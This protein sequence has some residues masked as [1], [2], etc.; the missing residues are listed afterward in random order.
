MVPQ[1]HWYMIDPIWTTLWGPWGVKVPKND[2]IVYFWAHWNGTI[3]GGKVVAFLAFSFAKFKFFRNFLIAEKTEV[4]WG[5]N[6]IYGMSHQ[7][8]TKIFP[9]NPKIRIKKFLKKNWRKFLNFLSN[10]EISE[11][12]EVGKP[13]FIKFYNI[14]TQNGSIPVSPKLYNFATFW[15]FDPS[16][17]LTE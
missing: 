17:N 11:K 2:K 7:N 15:N 12:F 5:Q 14:S 3:L 13:K 1:V 6:T 8:S 10:K 4:I 16:C 9:K